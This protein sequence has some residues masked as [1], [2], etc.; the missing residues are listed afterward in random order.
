MG[1]GD[2]PY[3]D[4]GITTAQFLFNH[5]IACFGVPQDIVTNHGSHFRQYMMEK[6][7]SQLGLRHD[8]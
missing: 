5:V 1:R 8:I 6:E 7:T 3:N 2:A 4:D